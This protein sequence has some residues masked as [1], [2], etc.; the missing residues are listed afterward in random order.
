[1]KLSND[2]YKFILRYQLQTFVNKTWKNFH[3]SPYFA[4]SF[5]WLSTDNQSLFK[6]KLHTKF[7]LGALINNPFV[8][9]S[10]I[11]VA[12]VFYPKVPFD[13]NSVFDFNTL[14][15]SL[16]PVNSFSLGLPNIVNYQN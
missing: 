3:F 15:N 7:G 2:L 14:K 5:G 4:T 10:N 1:M 9:F 8:T 11:Q 6:S 16:I 13:G 12:F